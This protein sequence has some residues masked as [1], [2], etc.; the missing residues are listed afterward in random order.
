LRR[1]TG[2]E[3]PTVVLEAPHPN[4]REM[5]TARAGTVRR[6]EDEYVVVAILPI[7]DRI[8]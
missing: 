8:T 3:T 4:S 6:R 1:V 5:A 2:A 7:L